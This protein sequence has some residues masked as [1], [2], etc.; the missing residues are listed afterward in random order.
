M[1][2]MY[3]SSILNIKKLC[4]LA[5]ISYFSLYMRT[6]GR[7]KS[8]LSLERKTKI[9]N[10]LIKDITPFVN[11]LGFDVAITRIEA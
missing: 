6:K 11:D 1:A 7:Y 4:Q 9:V 3:K 10:A 8:D 2:S 5:K